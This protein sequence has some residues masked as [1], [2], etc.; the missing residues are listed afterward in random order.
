MFH[1]GKPFQV[2]GNSLCFGCPLFRM[3]SKRQLAVKPDDAVYR[4]NARHLSNAD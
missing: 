1:V 4:L 3:A 2:V